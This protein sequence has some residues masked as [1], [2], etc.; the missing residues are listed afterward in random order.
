MSLCVYAFGCIKGCKWY[1]VER[2]STPPGKEGREG[3][4]APHVR[5]LSRPNTKFP[6]DIM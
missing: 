5:F 6:A 3:A 4:R 2:V 1:R